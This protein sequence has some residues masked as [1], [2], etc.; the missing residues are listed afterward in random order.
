V[1]CKS[2]NTGFVADTIGP[3]QPG[4]VVEIVGRPVA[5]Q[6][7]GRNKDFGQAVTGNEI[8]RTY[9]LPQ[10][11][12]N[13]R[14]LFGICRRKLSGNRDTV[15]PH[16]SEILAATIKTKAGVKR[17]ACHGPVFARSE[18]NQETFGGDVRAGKSPLGQVGRVI[19]EIPAAEIHGCCAAIVELDPVGV[20][21][22]L[23]D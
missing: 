6:G 7:S 9:V 16:Q 11:I 5:A 20:S 2:R 15:R 12:G 10:A 1:D 13:I 8:G 14:K 4:I 18:H 19:G 21:A 17:Q 23:I 3:T 22:V